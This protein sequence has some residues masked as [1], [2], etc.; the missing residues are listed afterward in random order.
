MS[1]MVI[2]AI[3][4]SDTG[5]DEVED[6][7]AAVVDEDVTAALKEKQA[8]TKVMKDERMKALFSMFDLDADGSVDFKE[9]ATG[10]YKFS[11]DLEGAAG[12]AVAALLLFDDDRNETLE[13]AEFSRFIL[14]LIEASGS[15]FDE[16]IL[17]MTK[18]AAVP[19]DLTPDEIM[20]Q[21]KTLAVAAGE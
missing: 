13:Y 1:E 16:A 17:K 11:H 12:T 8:L 7:I 10:F 18:A 3:C 14:Q 5:N 15:S 9:A 19:A 21:I 20:E 4:F 6:F 2:I